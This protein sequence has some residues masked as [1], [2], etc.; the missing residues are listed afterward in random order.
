[1]DAW[2]DL[3]VLNDLPYWENDDFFKC[4]HGVM[5]GEGCQ[6]CVEEREAK[7]AEIREKAVFAE[8]AFRDAGRCGECERTIEE[9]EPVY[10]DRV[11][12]ALGST[13]HQMRPLCESC[14]PVDLIARQGEPC[15]GCERPTVMPPT[16]R[17]RVRVFCSE[18]CRWRYYNAEAKER[19]TRAR[20]TTC[21]ECGRTFTPR[22]KDAVVCSPAC[23][24]VR[25]RRRKHEE[26]AA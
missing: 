14:A 4:A 1:M 9:G 7:D 12:K 5:Y 16:D 3:D 23:R 17:Q 25:Y 20:T 11:P 26:V 18:R 15:M 8:A 19:G 6:R 24:M 10:L 21:P 22:R 13:A 2:H